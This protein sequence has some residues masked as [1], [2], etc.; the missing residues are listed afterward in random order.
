MALVAGVAFAILWG[1]VWPLVFSLGGMGGSVLLARW[2]MRKTGLDREMERIE[3]RARKRAGELGEDRQVGV[4]PD[5][6]DPPHS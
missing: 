1:S 5:P 2:F 4:E 3:A 6:L